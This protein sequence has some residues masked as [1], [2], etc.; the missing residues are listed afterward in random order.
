MNYVYIEHF[1]LTFSVSR[2]TSY[3]LDVHSQYQN[4]A[5]GATGTDVCIASIFCIIGFSVFVLP[6]CI[7]YANRHLEYMGRMT[8]Q[9]EENLKKCTDLEQDPYLKTITKGLSK[10]TTM[11][12]LKNHVSLLCFCAPPTKL[13]DRVS[14]N[15]T[16][17]YCSCQLHTRKNL[18]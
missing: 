16:M 8:H 10:M 17:S 18:Q 3:V 1:S 6:I 14:Q 5:E 13:Q 2:R 9:M 7:L 12:Y 11:K 15:D 4:M